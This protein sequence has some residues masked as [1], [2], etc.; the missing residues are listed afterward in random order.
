M[1]TKLQEIFTKEVDRLI[2]FSKDSKY[3]KCSDISDHLAY[4]ALMFNS[5]ILLF[6]S[7]SLIYMFDNLFIAE[8]EKEV[9]EAKTI[10]K[11]VVAFLGKVKKLKL[12]EDKTK[13]EL[14]ELLIDIRYKVSKFQVNFGMADRLILK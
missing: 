10:N 2:K 9:K 14:I 7:E 6:L 8:V 1:E 11:D 13:G 4:T 5:K 12:S 3:N